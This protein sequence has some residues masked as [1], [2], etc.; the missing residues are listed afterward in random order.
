MREN[1]NLSGV[2]FFSSPADSRHAYGGR[3]Q[4]AVMLLINKRWLAHFLDCSSNYA[5]ARENIGY[6]IWIKNKWL[7][8]TTLATAGVLQRPLECR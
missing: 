3:L 1:V 7:Y 8:I 5:F 6:T 2:T 4:A